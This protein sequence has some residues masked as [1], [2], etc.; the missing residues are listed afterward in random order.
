[1]TPGTPI[2]S[3]LIA[4]LKFY[5]NDAE[6]AGLMRILQIA[7]Q[8]PYPLTD[9]GKVGIY[10]ITKYLAQRGHSITLATFRRKRDTGDLE[11]LT[12]FCSLVTVTLETGNSPFRAVMNLG[13]PIPYN[14]S[15]YQTARMRRR[16]S[17]LLAGSSFD[18]VHADHLHLAPYG[19]FCKKTAGL[20]VVLREHNI[21]S[22]ILLRYAGQMSSGAAGLFL[23][24][25]V[26]KIRRFEADIA[27]R[28]DRCCVISDEDGRRLQELQPAARISVIPA[29][30]DEA[31]FTPASGK[32]HFP[33]SICFVGSLD[34]R[35]NQ[36]A[37]RWLVTEIMPA[38]WDKKPQVSLAVIGKDPPG[39]LLRLG[40]DRVVF[41]GF[42][43][44][45]KSELARYRMCVVP[46]RIGGG[47]RLKI[48]ESFAMRLPVVS[49]AVGCEGIPVVDGCHLLTGNSAGEFAAQVLRLLNDPALGNS[50][51]QRAYELASQYRWEKVAEQFENVYREVIRIKS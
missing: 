39:D 24:R 45:L 29:G 8:I 35:A 15:K 1:M 5:R 43:D 11:E 40:S 14:I 48:L 49:T 46:L 30:V 25:Q 2:Q 18:V 51:S 10:N 41:R 28:C 50:L 23:S 9:G 20:P 13:S 38:I 44:D 7:P 16:L 36:D 12:K 4:L 3:I 42:V 6:K 19:L 37:V 21:E 33:D 22:T 47:I 32:E 26:K 27:S 31:Y 34:W 17:A